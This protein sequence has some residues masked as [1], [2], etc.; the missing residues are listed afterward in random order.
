M[1]VVEMIV[2]AAAAVVAAA[3]T[4]IEAMAT[5]QTITMRITL[6]TRRTDSN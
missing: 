2:V 4:T 6:V 5:T 1:A 3:V